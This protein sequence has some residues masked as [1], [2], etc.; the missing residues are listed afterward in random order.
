MPRRRYVSPYPPTQGRGPAHTLPQ[1]AANVLAGVRHFGF[2]PRRFERFV[3]YAALLLGLSPVTV[4]RYGRQ[5]GLDDMELE[6]GDDSITLVSSNQNLLSGRITAHQSEVLMRQINALHDEGHQ[7]TV[8]ALL[9]E[10]NQSGPHVSAS[11]LRRALHD[12]G[13]TWDKHR[14]KTS[15]RA[16]RKGLS[17]LDTMIQ[18]LEDNR[19]SEC[20]LPMMSQDE[21]FVK[22]CHRKEYTW[23]ILPED[24]FDTG[25]GMVVRPRP[26][27]C[28][29]LK[30]TFK[31]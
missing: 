5:A 17:M 20:S 10:V 21:S 18:V 25:A 14:R 27:Q 7:A 2:K 16:S 30:K 8:S 15:I 3:D 24:D 1:I 29:H 26:N 6:P 4:L 22:S 23:G 9:D 12:L 13:L 19:R 28:F 31:K 11:T